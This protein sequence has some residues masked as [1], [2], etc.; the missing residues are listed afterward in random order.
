[1]EAS[2]IK[3]LKDLE[4]E[5][6]RLK[7]MFVDLSFECRTLKDVI[8]K[9]YKNSGKSGACQLPY[10]T[11]FDEHPSR[12]PNLIAEQDGI[13]LQTGYPAG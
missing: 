12:L 8:E 13:L 3:R 4:E 5:N 10:R 2:D 7:Q 6:W 9:S 11:V 1:M